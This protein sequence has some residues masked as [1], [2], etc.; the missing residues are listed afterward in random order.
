MESQSKSSIEISTSEVLAAELIA[1][2][3]PKDVI[4]TSL[5]GITDHDFRENVI[6]EI[7]QRLRVEL[8]SR[9]NLYHVSNSLENIRVRALSVGAYDAAAL[10]ASRLADL[11]PLVT[12]P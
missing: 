11:L 8:L 4:F 6:T 10:A 1:S 2:G 3:W 9:L 12:K 5:K 7:S